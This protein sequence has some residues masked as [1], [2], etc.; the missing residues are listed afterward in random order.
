MENSNLLK[1][2]EKNHWI[3]LGEGLD[4]LV[5]TDA[6][7][8]KVF[9]V[10]KKS[11]GPEIMSKEAL[12]LPLIAAQ[13]LGATI[14]LP[15]IREQDDLFYAE[16]PFASGK[17]YVDLS[18]AARTDYLIK[19]SNFLQKLHSL[20]LADAGELSV[21]NSYERFLSVYKG[22]REFKLEDWL[23][24][25]QIAYAEKLFESYLN[26][27]DYKKVP[28]AIVHGDVSFEH[29]FYDDAG[30]LSIID[31]SD[32]HLADPAYDFHHLL[33]ELPRSAHAIFFEHYITPDDPTFW[34][35][36][37]DY[38][39]LD[40]FEVLLWRLT[41]KNEAKIK[42]YVRQIEADRQ[43]WSQV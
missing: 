38:R 19:L 16:Y 27:E 14:P 34:S 24:S 30:R 29:I 8:Q 28:P 6:D 5:Y 36:A 11:D 4:N 23:D 33:N 42:E 13:D 32:F 7:R 22:L 2:I 15:V 26:H 41:Q 43:E 9:R 1:F 37:Y 31:W 21:L 20:K 10:P 39:Y 12:L 3:Y 35:R 18:P 25:A 40:I 17:N